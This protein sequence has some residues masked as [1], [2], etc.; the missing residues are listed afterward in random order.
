MVSLNRRL[1][2]V[3][4][5]NSW[6]CGIFCASETWLND[7]TESNHVFPLSDYF[8]IARSDRTNGE[9][10]GAL[11]AMKS[12]LNSH[13]DIIPVHCNSN[14]GCAA[15]LSSSSYVLGIATVYNP[16]ASSRFRL[17]CSE[18]QYF[19]SLV[20]S[21]Y[22]TECSKLGCLNNYFLLGGDFSPPDIDWRT[23]FSSSNYDMNL[24]SIFQDS[25]L[26]QLIHEPTHNSGNILDILLTDRVL[27]IFFDYA[28]SDH[29]AV[30]VTF[31][32]HTNAELFPPSYSRSSFNF[33]TFNS[34]L[35]ACYDA[36]RYPHLREMFS[37]L[38][39]PTI[40]GAVA[41]S[42]QLKRKKRQQLP[43]YY[44]SSTVHLMN[45]LTS[46][47]RQF[48]AC[49]HSSL[50][51]ELDRN[52]DKLC[53]LNSIANLN[54]INCFKILKSISN[55]CT[56]PGTLHWGS[57]KARTILEKSNLFNRFFA[58]VFKPSCSVDV[59]QLYTYSSISLN[60]INISFDKILNFLRS[61]DDSS[62]V[63]CDNVPPAFLRYCS[64][65]LC[66]LVIA[67]YEDFLKHK[68]WPDA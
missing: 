23:S 51:L 9:H 32:M 67:L 30:G 31:S 5:L 15:I 20:Y 10:G 45:K 27:E 46:K 13:F 14:V 65:Q 57:F 50:A 16:P 25:N 55:K 11:I 49:D 58:S 68:V 43:F 19:L 52:L 24:I 56:F 2:V 47:T 7:S 61:A 22:R 53:Y 8:V 63:C 34:F 60:S 17:L 21:A 66:P 42:A 33:V 54:V 12:T 62:S 26:Q 44:S 29:R 64:N 37:T 4:L 38:L 18:V 41:A 39:I 59:L 6:N 35:D 36:L 28:L 48:P 40:S 1:Q 3:N